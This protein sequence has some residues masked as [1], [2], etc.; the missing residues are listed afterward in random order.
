MRRRFLC[1]ELNRTREWL[2]LATAAAAALLA[3]GCLQVSPQPPVPPTTM[4]SWGPLGGFSMTSGAPCA[5]KTSLADGAATVNDACFTGADNIVMCTDTT[6]AN[7]VK[8]TPG[9]G[10][11]AISGGVG[12]TIAYARVR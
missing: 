2:M 3:S 10:S 12:D 1:V 5:G 4:S 7:A 9:Y 6:A 8:C 11:L